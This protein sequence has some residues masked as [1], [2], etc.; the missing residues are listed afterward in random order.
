MG[1]GM[2]IDTKAF[3]RKTRWLVRCPDCRHEMAVKKRDLFCVC[4][5]CR[6]EIRFTFSTEEYIRSRKWAE[7][8]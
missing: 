2:M 8:A 5:L 7:H 6:R 3:R 4:K 1:T